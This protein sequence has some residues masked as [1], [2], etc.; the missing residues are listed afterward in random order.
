MTR[1]LDGNNRRRTSE[2]RLPAG[3]TGGILPPFARWR[4]EA[5]IPATWKVALRS[6]SEV[7]RVRSP[8]VS[9]KWRCDPRV[10]RR[11]DGSSQRRMPERPLPAGW[12]GGIL[13]P[14]A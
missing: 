14:F 12:T 1:R 13:P 11:L 10:T 4:L 2:R 3:W 6:E 5:D 9:E 8:A 7:L